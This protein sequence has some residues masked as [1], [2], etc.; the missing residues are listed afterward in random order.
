M[1]QST[2]I[3]IAALF[4]TSCLVRIIPAFVTIRLQPAMQR[5]LEQVLPVAVF[6]N[7]AVYI[8]YSEISREPLAASI[9]LLLVGVIALTNSL[10]L[11]TSAAL[12]A[13]A[14][15]AVMHLATG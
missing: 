11:I 13:A 6:I 14:Y 7:F 1:T 9:S 12:G 10:G 2:W 15:F 4:A 5:C 8:A 3:T